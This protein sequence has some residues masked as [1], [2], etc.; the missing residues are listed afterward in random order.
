MKVNF[1]KQNNLYNNRAF[2]TEFYG[3]RHVYRLWPIGLWLSRTPFPPKLSKFPILQKVY[4]KKRLNELTID[5]L[6]YSSLTSI[7]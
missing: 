3:P 7:I 6:I 5:I 2:S 4:L 1:V